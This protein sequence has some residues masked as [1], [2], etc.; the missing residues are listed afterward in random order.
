MPPDSNKIAADCFKKGLE[1]INKANWD[2]AIDMCTKAVS[3]V[4]DN[5]FYR[6]TLRGAEERKY[7]NNKTGARMLGLRLTG[8]R[9]RISRARMKSDWSALDQASEEGLALNPWD[10]QL[11]ADLGEAG[12]HLGYADVAVFCYERAVENEGSNKEFLEKLANL[13]ELRGRYTDAIGCWRRVAKIDPLDSQARS[14]STQLEAMNMMDRG[15]YEDA[16]STQDVKT[17]YDFDR[18][19]KTAIP[20]AFDGPGS[21][22]EADLQRAIR[23]SPADKNNYLKLADLYSRDRKLSEAH[24]TLKKALEVSGGDPN[25]RELLEDNELEQMRQNVDLARQNAA[26]DPVANKNYHEW[27]SEL[28]KREIE[29]FSSRVERYPKDSRWKYEL[30]QRYIK[31]KEWKKAIPLLQQSVADVRLKGDVLVALAKCFDADNNKLLARRQL[32]QAVQF[33]NAHDRT[34]LYAE[35]HYY[36]ALLCEQAGEFDQ[37]ETHYHEVLSVDY[38]FADARERLEKLQQRRRDK[39]GI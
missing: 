14:K 15:G 10:A 13:Y 25:V 20:D 6:Q 30:A 22:P 39:P 24:E 19:V 9:T 17:G 2:Y 18:P 1:A 32:E 23:K 7:N 33:I 12:H 37:A 21:S 5:V 4:P 38:A 11:N 36:L 16:R 26:T 29:I 27:K 35:A 28:R 31:M 8:I 34:K 3:L